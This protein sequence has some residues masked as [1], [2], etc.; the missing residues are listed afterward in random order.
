MR[1]DAAFGD[2]EAAVGLVRDLHL[3]REC[4][5]GKAPRHL[6]AAQHLVLEVV[7]G[8]RAENAVED[9]VAALDDSGDAQELLAGFGLELAPQLVRAAKERH[10]VGVLEVR[11]PDDPRQP[12][13]RA[14]LVEQV[15]TLEPEDALAA[16]GEVVE[17]SAPHSADSD[18]DDVVALHRA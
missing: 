6:G 9:A 12:V 4:V 8:A 15:E 13:R 1:D 17:R 11:E 7:L 10:V 3:G 16:A 2:D 18:D 14:L 5:G